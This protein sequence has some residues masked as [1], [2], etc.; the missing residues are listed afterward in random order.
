[1]QRP[2]RA[3]AVVGVFVFAENLLERTVRALGELA[4][5]GS[6]LQDDARAAGVP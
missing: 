2:E 3:Q 5:D 1:M 6:A 4:V